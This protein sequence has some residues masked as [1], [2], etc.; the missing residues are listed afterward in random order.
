MHE[1]GTIP[2]M[3]TYDSS[4]DASGGQRLTN[5]PPQK[6]HGCV[7]NL[8]CKQMNLSHPMFKSNDCS[9]VFLSSANEVSQPPC[10]L[11]LAPKI[12]V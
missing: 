5:E 8:K 1:R 2:L 11:V 9:M 6:K 12:T 10:V 7:P 3:V 4:T